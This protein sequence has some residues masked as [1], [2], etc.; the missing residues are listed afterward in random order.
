MQVPSLTRAAL[1]T[2]AIA[3]GGLTLIVLVMLALWYR[4][5]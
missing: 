2:I 5:H 4:W 1:W 3:A